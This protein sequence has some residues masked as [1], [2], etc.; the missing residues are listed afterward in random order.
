MERRTGRGIAGLTVLTL[1][2][3]VGCWGQAPAAAA[4]P[5]QEQAS[6]AGIDAGLA[7]MK[8]GDNA[9]A[10]DAF[11]QVVKSDPNNAT[12]NLLAASAALAV[13]KG[14]LAIKYAERALELDP[15]DWKIHTTLVAAY[16]AG[17]QTHQRD[18]E[19][20]LLRK[21]HD[22]PRAPD[23]LKSSGFLLEMFPVKDYRV[24]AV[25]YFQPVGKFH[26]YYRFLVRDKQGKRVWE[27]DAQS[28]DFD[29]KSWAQAHPAEAK[30]G[31]RQY[32]LEGSG[33][34]KQVT[35]RTFSGNPSYDWIRGEV[36]KIVQAQNGAFAGAASAQ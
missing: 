4:G 14:E 31:Q 27:I 25:E 11:E 17:G 9:K 10:L 5:S 12:A 20:D 32:A 36:V 6:R 18:E 29:Q 13:Y 3:T 23:A 22:D 26:I 7:A 2:L 30:Q 21:L 24:D 1:V 34:D 8:A 16:A 28:D 15:K 33:G 35:Y 19:R